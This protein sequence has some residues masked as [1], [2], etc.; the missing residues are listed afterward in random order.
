MPKKATEDKK[1]FVLDTNVLLHNPN[2]LFVFKEHHVVIPFPVIEE[3]DKMKRRDDDIGR[4]ARQC[5]RHLDRLRSIG[6]LTEGVQWGS[7]A[8]STLNGDTGAIRIDV[9]DDRRP[10]ALSEDKPDNLII[11]VAWRLNEQGMR[12]VFVSK[13]LGARIKSDAL[14]I[15]TEDFENQKVDADALYSGYITI[16]ADG[17]TSDVL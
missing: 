1:H 2:A 7:I 12:A 9:A 17:D 10:P 15:H 6:R 13:D 8:P 11:S 3:L 5:I 16:G 14:G 4:N